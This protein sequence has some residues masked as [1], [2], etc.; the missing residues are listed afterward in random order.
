MSHGNEDRIEANDGDTMK[1]SNIVKKFNDKDC[2]H[3][4]GQPK[5]FIFQ[6]C[7]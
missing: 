4:K 1:I 2:S 3:L 6:C 7:R 5:V